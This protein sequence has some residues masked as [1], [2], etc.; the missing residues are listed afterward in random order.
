MDLGSIF[1]AA[2]IGI[3]A[4]AATYAA[5][6]FA[7]STLFT[8]NQK[9]EA[10][11]TAFGKHVRT[12][13]SPGLHLKAPWPFQVVA[14]KIGTDLQQVQE[15]LATKTKDDLF[16]ELPI[17]IQYEISDPAKYHFENRAAVD[18]MK[19]A[20]SAAVRTSTSGKQ[21]QELYSDRDEISDHVIAQ[22]KPT[23][24][25]YGINLRRIII[26][27][28]TAPPQVQASYNE[29]RASE[30]MME[31]AKN[32]AGAHKIELVARAE[33]EKE[34]D[35]LRGQ[36]KAGFR[37]ALF[38]QYGEQIESLIGKGVTREEAIK[39]MLDTMH[40]DTMRDIGHQGNMVI[41]TTDKSS[42]IGGGLA[43]LQ[44]LRPKQQPAGEQDVRRAGGPAVAAP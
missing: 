7:A 9:Q 12:E 8:V 15:T 34:A 40:Q 18:N 25:E 14:A 41:V 22:I 20:V 42:D 21:F 39:V 11:I 4:L 26:D 10:L 32:K 38:D 13:Q 5:V 6:K 36:G 27:E 43:A 19:K 28:P 16:V 29:V 23:I 2:A 37:K 44:T 33:A 35:I 1:H 31:A 24:A 30:R 17:A 3:P